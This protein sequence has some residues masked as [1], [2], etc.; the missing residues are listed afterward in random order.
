LRV[1]LADEA[2]GK[3]LVFVRTDQDGQAGIFVARI[4]GSGLRQIPT[5]G[6]I[7]DGDSGGSR[8][9]NGN[10]ISF[11][12]RTD[13]DHRRGICV[14]NA[15]GSACTSARL[16]IPAEGPLSDPRSLGSGPGWSPDRTKIVFTRVSAKRA[17]SNIYTVNGDGSGLFQ[18][19][20][21]GGGSEADWGT[22]P[23]AP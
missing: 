21:S 6:L 19:T 23:L 14:V 7:L 1:I 20:H 5:P 2:D 18:V 9:P 12:A 4:N 16:N 15:D 3:S 13:P 10:Q 8:A 11:A 17:Q 22:H